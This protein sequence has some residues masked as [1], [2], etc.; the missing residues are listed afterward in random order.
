MD[1]GKS[2]LKSYTFHTSRPKE[3]GKRFIE[4]GFTPLLPTLPL[5]LLRE[6]GQGDGLLNNLQSIIAVERRRAELGSTSQL[7][8]LFQPQ[9]KFL[10]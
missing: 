3:R 5:P 9:T 1:K 8:Q 2:L 10:R 6:G 7:Y 4:R